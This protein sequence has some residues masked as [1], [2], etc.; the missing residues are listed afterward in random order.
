MVSWSKFID[1]LVVEGSCHEVGHTWCESCLEATLEIFI[2]CVRYSVKLYSPI[3]MSSQS[4]LTV[5]RKVPLPLLSETKKEIERMH[6]LG[7]IRPVQEPTDWCTTIV[8]IPK[9]NVKRNASLARPLGHI[10]SSDGIK[11]DPEKIRSI[12]ILP[13]P[14]NAAEVK[15]FLGIGNQQSKF[16]PDLASK[17]KPL[18]D[19]LNN[20][21]TWACGQP[22]QKAFE[23]IKRC[24]P[25]REIIHNRE[26]KISADASSYGMGGVV[27]QLQDD[28][29]WKSIAYFSRDLASIETKYS[30]IEKECFAFTWLAE[31]GSD[32]ILGKEIT[33]ET[34]TSTHNSLH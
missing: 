15:S 2:N 34:C 6:E 7:V 31:R 25:N 8:I 22:Q 17:T 12:L 27:Y 32:Y 14:K 30:Q 4:A 26:S 10:V 19:L 21:C 11:P 28:N 18:R 24:L 1:P 9:P 13:L 20:G 16:A 5:P 33:G 29:N 23:D 3:Y